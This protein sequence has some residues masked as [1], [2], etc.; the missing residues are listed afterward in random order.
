MLYCPQCGTEYREGFGSCS[1]CRLALVRVNPRKVTT[2]VPPEPG[3]PN[4]DPFCAFWQGDDQRI[5]AELCAVLD[6]AR[7]PHKTVYRKDHLFNLSNCPTY[8]VGVPASRFDEAENAIRDAFSSDSSE[9]DTISAL[10]PPSILP[11]RKDRIRKLPEML[12]PQENIPGPESSGDSA[13]WFEEDATAL[14]WS[15][16]DTYLASAILG[17]LNE[18]DLHARRE[19]QSNTTRLFVFPA[20]ESRAREIIREIVEAAPPE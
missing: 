5:H 7:I 14:V 20:E 18:N 19:M 15:G 12:T 11:D 2:Q 16:K 6:D 1:D 8:Q 9:A 4:R 17:A 3:D 13:V 10:S